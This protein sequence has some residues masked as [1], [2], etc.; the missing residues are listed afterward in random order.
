M[1]KRAQT[2][3]MPQR[4]VAMAAVAAGL[5]GSIGACASRGPTPVAATESRGPS[6]RVDVAATIE[7]VLREEDTDG[8]GIVS[9]AD[10]GDR[11]F[12]MRADDGRELLVEGTY[13]LGNLVQE[14]GAA[15][16][17]G[18]AAMAEVSSRAIFMPPAD[19]VSFMIRTR[20]W[21]WLT[22]TVDAAGLTRIVE[23][24]KRAGQPARVYVPFGDARAYAYYTTLAAARPELKLTVVR[25]PERITPEY[26]RSLNDAPGILSLSLR[27]DAGEDAR[28]GAGDGAA[29]S[30]AMRGEP[31]VVPGGRFNEMYGWDSYFIALGL[32][33]DDRVELAR[34]MVDNFVYQIEHYG[35][36]LNANRTYYLTRSQPPFL[37]SMALAVFEKMPQDARSREWL[38]RALR[39]AVREYNTVWAIE[40]RLT[41]TGLS[42]YYGTGLGIPPEVEPG[43]FDPII[44]PLARKAGVGLEE[45]VA[46]Y[47][48]GELESPELDAML[49]HDRAM[50]ESGHDTSYRLLGRAADLNTV[51]LNSLLYKYEAD[52]ANAID[53]H[54]G[55]RLVLDSGGA[56]GERSVTAATFRARA[57]ARKARMMDLMWDDEQSLFFDYDYVHKTRLSDVSATTLYPL[58]AG[59]LDEAHAMRLARAALAE[60]EM[61]GG[62]VSG[63]EE[64]RGIV[65]EPGVTGTGERPPRQW[66][67]PFGWAPHQMIAWEGL[68]RYGMDE[69]ARR[70]A[71][72]WTYMIAMN[73]ARSNGAIVEK[74]DVVAR[75]IDASAEYGNV[76]SRFRL[77]PD[78]GF[79]WTNASFQVGVSLLTD[80]ERRDLNA[81]VPPEWR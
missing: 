14:L 80:D 30:V 28:D 81:L 37:T 32:L 13:E 50:R 69:D 62:I 73:A 19:H 24:P 33:A 55:V 59:M 3:A 20:Y 4:M 29:G 10:A 70:L 79:G 2:C 49:R 8:D 42:R 41:P 71:Y 21:D 46:R 68:R 15:Q 25:L 7:R 6:V 61:P 47:A 76:G 43:H 36:I 53:E 60:L 56:G 44:A 17:S 38:G 45:F 72:R 77:V 54:F 35:K 57:A 26:V 1:M 16:R 52:L 78:G 11:R 22:R 58:W 5:V 40:P 39:A 67:Y 65:D 63:T 51:A 66:D 75:S 12:V 9:I 31:F 23:D 34:G 48:S 74:Y 18:D 27:E 64:S